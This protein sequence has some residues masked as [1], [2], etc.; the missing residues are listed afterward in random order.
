M[1]ALYP[2]Q[3]SRTGG[4][5]CAVAPVGV[6]RSGWPLAETLGFKFWTFNLSSAVSASMFAILSMLRVTWMQCGHPD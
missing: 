5:S 3:A 1:A 4:W 2:P 6:E